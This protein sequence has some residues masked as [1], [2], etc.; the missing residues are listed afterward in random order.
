MGRCIFWFSIFVS[1]E[2]R[3]SRVF[4][5][6]A[7]SIRWSP[8]NCFFFLCCM[9]IKHIRIY[10]LCAIELHEMQ[11]RAWARMWRPSKRCNCKQNP[12][13]ERKNRKTPASTAGALLVASHRNKHAQP[14]SASHHYKEGFEFTPVKKWRKN[15]HIKSANNRKGMRIVNSIRTIHAIGAATLN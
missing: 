15:R 9:H 12:T 13:E 7:F 3:F 10:L 4:S 5:S 14:V 11:K 1:A 6:L 2:I 8:L